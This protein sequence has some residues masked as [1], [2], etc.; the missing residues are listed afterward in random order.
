MVYKSNDAN[1]ERVT[2]DQEID[3]VALLNSLWRKKFIWISFTVIFTVIGTVYAL[4]LPNIYKSEVV[5]APASDTNQ[6]TNGL[7]NQ[8]GG[9]ASLAG[10]SIGGNEINK[11]TIAL[12]VLKSRSFLME[13]IKENDLKVILMGVKAWERNSNKF[14]YDE[15]KYDFESQQWVRDVEPPLKAEPSL[16]EAQQYFLSNNLYLSK[17][18]DTGLITIGVKHYSPY[19]AKELVDKLISAIN[20]KMKEKDIKEA[21]ASIK[22]LNSVL[23]KTDVFDMKSMFYSLIE[24]QHQTIMLATVR[25]DYVF[26]VIDPAVVEE[27]RFSPKRVGILIMFMSIGFLLGVGISLMV[28]SGNSNA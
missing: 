20:L 23:N 15:D 26:Q 28:R 27:K 25:A 22:Y 13:F 10:M 12:E 4:S 2:S 6:G 7:T 8:L 5:L 21:E 19:L 16:L 17:D 18:E 11:T 9:L 14:I 1:A 24:E 3:L